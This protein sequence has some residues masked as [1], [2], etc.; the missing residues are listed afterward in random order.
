[1]AVAG[2]RRGSIGGWELSHKS[3]SG[4]VT[5]EQTHER[6]NGASPV[7]VWGQTTQAD[8]KLK[9]KALWKEH[10]HSM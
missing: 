10:A 4:K 7:G 3:F 5:S 6:R 2:K 1:M 9:A 8:R